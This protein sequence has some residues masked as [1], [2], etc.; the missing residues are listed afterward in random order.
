M[1]FRVT[2]WKDIAVGSAV[3]AALCVLVPIVAV[4]SI[5]NGAPTIEQLRHFTLAAVVALFISLPLSVIGMR[6]MMAINQTVDMV[7]DL[8]RFDPLTGVLCRSHFYHTWRESRRNG[9]FLAI[10]DADHFKSVND[11]FGHDGGDEAL[12]HLAN[13]MSQAVPAPGL[14]GRLG[15][16]E[17]CIYMPTTTRGEARMTMVQIA[18]WLRTHPFTAGQ[19]SQT[20]S[21]SIGLTQDNPG[22]TIS[23][24]IRRADKCLYAAKAAGRDRCIMETELDAATKA[25]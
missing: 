23:N 10:V 16:E 5:Y 4:S 6:M 14:V 19:Q 2:S 25:A 8:V 9:G 24:V 1:N 12:K 18:Q 3:I 17:F 21:V 20:I 11:T 7:N 15:G 22:E 13:A